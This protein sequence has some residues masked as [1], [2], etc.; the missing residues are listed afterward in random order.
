MFKNKNNIIKLIL[1]VIIVANTSFVQTNGLKILLNFSIFTF[2]IL[3]EFFGRKISH[4]ILIVTIG[5]L[6]IL[7]GSYLFEDNLKA[8]WWIIDDHEIITIMGKDKK[9]TLKEFVYAYPKTEAG[10]PG[11]SVRYRPSYYFLRLTEMFI[12]S[13]QPSLWYLFRL[14]IPIFM[15]FVIWML[16]GRWIGYGIGGAFILNILSYQFWSDIFSRLGPGETYCVLGSTI[17]I[18][19]AYLIYKESISKRNL[20][21]FL[22]LVGSIIAVGSKENF[23]FILF[24]LFLIYLDLF[25]NK[26]ITKFS[27]SMFFITMAYI[28]FVGISI[29]I[30]INNSGKDIYSNSTN[31]GQRIQLLSKAINTKLG[32][33]LNIINT[34]VLIKAINLEI[35][36][37][38]FPKKQKIVIAILLL[39]SFYYFNFIFY[40]GAWPTGNRYDFPAILI[41]PISIL[42]IYKLIFCCEKLSEKL[43]LLF[44]LFIPFLNGNFF[45]IRENAKINAFRTQLFTD[46]IMFI[47]KTAKQFPD[48][49]IIIEIGEIVDYEPI[50]SYQRFLYNMEVKNKTY[51]KSHIEKAQLKSSL[52]EVLSAQIEDISKNGLAFFSPY[53]VDSN[54]DNC[55]A[56]QI[57]GDWPSNCEKIDVSDIASFH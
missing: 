31:F 42:L 51:L 24:P 17:L 33:S 23:I 26:K 4:K 47:E 49:K 28:L 50:I 18:S 39:W 5:V 44:I 13:N 6:S 52:D 15:I 2:L 25:Q 29:F 22:I 8:K 27:S 41:L 36:K 38:F 55:I 45:K 21:W 3:L 53:D 46:R 34:L 30:A 1:F 11:L 10:K 14:A 43:I 12:W 9:L 48:K 32:F 57:R 7:F 20:G 56:I 35:K 16:I 37:K 19:G 54:D 40:N